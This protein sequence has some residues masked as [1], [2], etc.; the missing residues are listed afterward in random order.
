MTH[1]P[2]ATRLTSQEPLTDIRVREP[3]PHAVTTKYSAGIAGITAP[4]RLALFMHHL[5]GCRLKPKYLTQFQNE[6]MG[7]YLGR[8]QLPLLAVSGF[9]AP[10]CYNHRF[11]LPTKRVQQ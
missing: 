7:N 10:G 2:L 5:H 11:N 4:P 1:H 3:W 8:V 9:A 6:P